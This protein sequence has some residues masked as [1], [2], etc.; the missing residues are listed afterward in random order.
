M[1]ETED[2]TQGFPTKP[3]PVRGMSR[4]AAAT[5]FA[6]CRS[7]IMRQRGTVRARATLTPCQL[8]CFDRH[9][10]DTLLRRAGSV[11]DCITLASARRRSAM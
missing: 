4:C 11:L 8:R 9:D 3:A 7:G 1:P 5:T 6:A 2:G 10:P